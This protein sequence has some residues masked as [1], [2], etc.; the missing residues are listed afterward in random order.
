MR[1][2]R[3]ASE[4]EPPGTEASLEIAAR[5][6]GTR[7]RSRWE[8]ERR[9]RRARAPETVIES[10]LNHLARLGLVDD[11][12]FARWWV[13]QRDRHAP[14]GKR[15]VEAELRQHGIG[16]DVIEQLRDDLAALEMGAD[17]FGGAAAVDGETA[18]EDVPITEEARARTALTQHLRGRPLPEDRRALQRVGMF[19]IRRGFDPETVRSAMSATGTTHGESE[20]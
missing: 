14:R 13:E 3:T 7:P 10:T 8:V 5:F 4:A 17:S 2:R 18:E 9:L 1:R 15:L 11:L 6:L 16:R 20:R 19:L 12:A